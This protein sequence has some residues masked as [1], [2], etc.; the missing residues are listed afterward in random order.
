MYVNVEV[1]AVGDPRTPI[2]VVGS[3]QHA[4]GAAAVVVD[5]SPARRP[6]WSPDDPW[7]RAHSLRTAPVSLSRFLAL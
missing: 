2:R 3:S 7:H 5:T 6:A 4:R 1:S